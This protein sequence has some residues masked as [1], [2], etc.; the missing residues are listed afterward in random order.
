MTFSASQQQTTFTDELIA[1]LKLEWSYTTAHWRKQDL[2]GC[3][4]YINAL[5]H[6]MANEAQAIA[7]TQGFAPN[8]TRHKIVGKGL[9]DLLTK[10]QDGKLVVVSALTG[11]SEQ[12]KKFWKGAVYDRKLLRQL[13]TQLVALG[14]FE[15]EGGVFAPHHA[16]RSPIPLIKAVDLES[17]LVF[18]EHL[19]EVYC[20]KK[21]GQRWKSCGKLPKHQGKLTRLIYNAVFRGVRKFREEY[22][23]TSRL[24][25]EV[26][27]DL[28]EYYAEIALANEQIQ[29]VTA[30]PK[31]KKVIPDIVCPK[32]TGD[33]CDLA[34]ESKQPLSFDDLPY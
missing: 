13:R 17:L 9:A 27:E 30:M 24:E 16:G 32:D 14:L 29:S 5:I 4:G 6:Q 12:I 10:A 33:H 28:L 20:A 26:P 7:K 18:Y 8:S 3:L 34:S 1:A 21:W 2:L 23:D 19:E 15:C 11:M 25:D 22:V 31:E